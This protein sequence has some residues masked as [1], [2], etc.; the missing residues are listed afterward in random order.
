MT[1]NIKP[2]VAQVAVQMATSLWIEEKNANPKMSDVSYYGLVALCTMTLQGR[3]S[4]EN[5]TSWAES[6]LKK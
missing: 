1:D 3:Y 6:L 4:P 5:A 2:D